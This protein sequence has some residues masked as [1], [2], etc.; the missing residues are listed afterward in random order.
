MSLSRPGDSSSLAAWLAYLEQLH[1]VSIEMGLDRVLAVANRLQL[2]QISPTIITV[3]GTNGKGS[4]VAMLEAIYCAAGYT[5]GAYTSPHIR[6]FN[7]RIHIDGKPCA[8]ATII[9]ALDLVEQSREPQ[10]LTYFEHTTLGAMQAFVNAECDVVIL[11]VGLGGRLDATNVWDADCAVVTSVAVDHES[12]LGSDRNVIALEKVAIG[13]PGRPLIIGEPDPPQTM[14]EYASSTG[15]LTMFPSVDTGISKQLK[16]A[17]QH[18][19]AACALAV[20]ATLVD[21]LPVSEQIARQAIAG[22]TVPGRF[23]LQHRSGVDI[24]IDVAHNPA[25][26]TGLADTLIEHF[27]DA[28]IH[29]VFA[30]LTDKDIAGV[31]AVLDRVVDHWYCAK[32]DVPRATPLELLTDLVSANSASTTVSGYCSV[33]LAWEAALA[34]IAASNSERTPLVLVAGSFFTV[35]ALTDYW[36]AVHNS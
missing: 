35:S 16:G 15:M 29:A 23:E 25:A 17:H 36:N 32:L 34:K 33:G 10:S 14:L 24:V 31:V 27:P 2:L 12:Y 1:P 8:D 4:T 20:V 26:A 21:C 5:V 7:E 13:R 6:K 28:D 30:A 3:A 19:N 11:E 18:R 9:A 22:V